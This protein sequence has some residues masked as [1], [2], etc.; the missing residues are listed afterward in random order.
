MRVEP[1][2]VWSALSPSAKY[3]DEASRCRIE[4][5]KLSGAIPLGLEDC[6]LESATRGDLDLRKTVTSDHDCRLLA[7]LARRSVEEYAGELIV[8]IHE[9][10]RG[11]LDPS[12]VIQAYVGAPVRERSH[13]SAFISRG[14]SH[15][16]AR[17][18]IHPRRDR[19]ALGGSRGRRSEGDAEPQIEGGAQEHAGVAERVFDDDLPNPQSGAGGLSP[20][21]HHGDGRRK[22][23]SDQAIPEPAKVPFQGSQPF[24]RRRK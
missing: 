5:E 13:P 19:A 4:D 1:F 20:R 6:P 10:A 12:L 2:S 18:L 24:G 21:G 14:I 8:R 22:Q 11:F 17:R 9:H 7:A 16:H 3:V 15:D 23:A